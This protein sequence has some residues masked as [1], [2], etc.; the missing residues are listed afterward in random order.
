[1]GQPRCSWENNI[2]M[3]LREIGWGNLDWADLDQNRNQRRDPF[4]TV[5]NIWVL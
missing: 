2:K 4:N 3:N 5:T 1:V